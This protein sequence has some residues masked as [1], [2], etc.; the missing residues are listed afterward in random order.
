[1]ARRA[2]LA[3]FLRAR[4]AAVRPEDV[5]LPGGGRRRT[6]GLRREEVALLAGVSVSWY[7]W[8]EQGRPINASL[9]VLD[10]LARALHL[11]AV[12]RE[13]LIVLVGYPARLPIAPG[14][15]VVSGAIERLLDAL[16][17]APAYVLGPRWDFLGWNRSFMVLFPAVAE[18][19]PEERNLVWVLFANAQA[20]ELVG[21]WE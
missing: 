10:A 12:E 2:D 15:D 17:P 6:Q 14:R 3:A 9:D 8:L 21:E 7:T 16:E 11:D 5:G 4:R 18:L 13:H 1:M 20:R 19:P